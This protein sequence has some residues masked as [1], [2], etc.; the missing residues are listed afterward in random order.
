MQKSFS[1]NDNKIVL[2]FTR[3][4]CD[5]PEKILN[6]VAFR[7]VLDLY[8]TIIKNKQNDSFKYIEA[9]FNELSKDEVLDFVINGFKL[10]VSFKGS[11]ISKLNPSYEPLVNNSDFMFNF[12][13]GFYA[14]WRR[15]ERYS[16]LRPRRV[17]S[18]IGKASFV[19]ANSKFEE[20]ILHLYR[21]IRENS[22]GREPRVYRQLPAG[23]NASLVLNPQE[24]PC[25]E[26]YE[27]LKRVPFIESILLEQPV[28]AYPKQNT[29]DG[30]FEEVFENPLADCEINPDNWYC[31]PAKI[32]GLLAYIY[33]NKDFMIHGISLCNLF[34]RATEKYVKGN[35]PDIVYVYGGPNGSDELKTVFYDDKKNDLMIGFVNH[36]ERIDYFGYMKKMCLT[37]HNLISIKKGYLPIHGAM[38]NIVMKDGSSANVVIMGDS[39]AGKSESLEAFRSL[40]NDYISKMITVFDDM[41]TLRLDETNTNGKPLAFGTEIGAFVR[42]DDLEPGFAFEEIDRSIFMNPHKVNARLIVPVASYKDIM[43]GY[44]IDLFLYANNYEKVEGDKEEISMFDNID[45]AKEVFVSGARMAKGT[46]TETGLVKSYFANPFGPV[47]WKE[48]TDILI[49]KYFEQLYKSGVKVGQMRTSLGIPGMAQ[50]GPKKAALKLFELIK[51]ISK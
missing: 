27:D 25:P 30:V 5:T 16:I 44:P 9:H 24:W 4:F 13:E 36:H 8:L 7:K 33:F 49:E 48:K 3:E 47:Q 1:L 2:D 45:E 38:V 19:S 21:V 39:G 43:K 12:I 51:S 28:I 31:Y 11:E 14:Y 42:L 22:T 26:E 10:L 20:L 50:E 41:G 29:R 18:G 46:T 32:G 34:E 6:S 37:L 35:K 23:V 17:E 40:S 15:L